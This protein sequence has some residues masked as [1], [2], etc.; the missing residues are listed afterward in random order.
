MEFSIGGAG[1]EVVNDLK[2]VAGRK[3]SIDLDA[4]GTFPVEPR[5]FI[6]ETSGKITTQGEFEY[7]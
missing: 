1:G 6:L 2:R 4:T 5:F 3:T 7:G